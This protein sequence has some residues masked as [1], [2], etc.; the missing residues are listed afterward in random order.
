MQNGSIKQELVNIELKLKKINKVKIYC[1]AFS[2][3]IFFWERLL[4]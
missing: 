3:Q 2:I 1:F 4:M